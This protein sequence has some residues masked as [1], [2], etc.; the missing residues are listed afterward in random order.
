MFER[1]GDKE[2]EKEKGMR[3][4][5][6]ILTELVSFLSYTLM[7]RLPFATP[8]FSHTLYPNSISVPLNFAPEVPVIG[9]T[10]TPDHSV[11]LR[12][13]EREA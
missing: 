8:I 7:S 13:R 9:P 3:D 12:E 11:L 5:D 6:S 1:R 2:T 10:T 4:S